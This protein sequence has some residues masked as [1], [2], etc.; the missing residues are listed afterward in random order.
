M[1][2]VIFI[3]I[4]IGCRKKETKKLKIA[5]SKDSLTTNNYV[6]IATG[7]YTLYDTDIIFFLQSLKMIPFAVKAQII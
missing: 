4:L 5:I 3:I 6:K 7:Q 1:K 2:K